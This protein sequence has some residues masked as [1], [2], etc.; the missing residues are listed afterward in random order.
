MPKTDPTKPLCT[1][2]GTRNGQVIYKGRC[3]RCYEELKI[4]PKS[5][6]DA[7]GNLIA[8]ARTE[9]DWKKLAGVLAPTVEA[10]AKGELKAS[11]AQAAML[12]EVLARAYGK[13]TKSQQDAQGP[14]G[15]VML[16]TLGVGAST[17]LCKKCL[18]AH[19]NHGV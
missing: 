4:V 2:C 8:A 6:L 17:Q 9:D 15:I 19:P 3:H 13:V 5:P 11:A 1:R 14:S 16:P 18:E 10:I 12:K 7:L